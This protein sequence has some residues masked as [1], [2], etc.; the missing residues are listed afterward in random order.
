MTEFTQVEY[1]CPTCQV[2]FV[3]IHQTDE[4]NS[5]CWW[6]GGCVVLTGKVNKIEG[7]ELVTFQD[8]K[9]VNREMSPEAKRKK[10]SAQ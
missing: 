6:C 1:R 10:R 4:R 5:K 8:G 3:V 7:D 9:E 2:P